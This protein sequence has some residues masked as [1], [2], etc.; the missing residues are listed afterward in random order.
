MTCP[1]CGVVAL[2]AGSITTG[3]VVG[4]I[5]AGTTAIVDGILTGSD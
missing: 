4:G 2:V 3:A 1:P 5:G